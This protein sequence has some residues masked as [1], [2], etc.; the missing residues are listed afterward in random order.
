MRKLG[1]K[2]TLIAASL[3]ACKAAPEPAPAEASA[4]STAATQ[5]APPSDNGGPS[6]TGTTAAP[7]AAPQA[8]PAAAGPRHYGETT[9]S[10]SA[11][12]GE[13]FGVALESNVTVP[14][15][16]RL[17]P[18]DPKVLGLIEEKQHESPP[19]GCADCVGTGGTKV[20]LFEAKA[21]GTASL[22]FALKPLMNPAGQSQKDVTLSVTVTP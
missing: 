22:H 6:S 20:F 11:R 9:K 3:V 2:A 13:R 1:L 18:P 17:D 8:A 12:P 5:E 4:P 10:I 15:K 19:P 21:P 16:W 14:F 7:A